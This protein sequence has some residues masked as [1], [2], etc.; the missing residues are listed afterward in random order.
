MKIALVCPNSLTADGGVKEHSLNKDIY[1]F[2]KTKHFILEGSEIWPG[3]YFDRRV[4]S[5]VAVSQ[6]CKKTIGYRVFSPSFP[7]S[8]RRGS[9]ALPIIS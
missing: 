7:Q 9:K 5:Y 2:G 3:W 4:S 1:L 6:A 8:C